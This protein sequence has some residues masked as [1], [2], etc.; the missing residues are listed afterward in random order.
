MTGTV[1]RRA[2]RPR[3]TVPRSVR[4]IDAHVHLADETWAATMGDDRAR[5]IARAFGREQVVVPVH[6]MAAEYRDR[7]MMAVI[8]NA[9]DTTVTGR[10]SVPNDHIAEVVAGDPD[11]FFGMGVIDPWQGKLAER[12]IDHISELG[13][14]GVGELNP[15][16]QHFAPNDERFHP[17]WRRA[18]DLGLV[19][20]FHGGYAAAGS[21]T[22]GGGGVKLRFARPILLDDVAADF[23][24]LRIVCAHPSWPWESEALAVTMHKRN[25]FLDLSGVA[26]RYLSDEVRRYVRRRISDKVLFG[27]DWPSLSVERWLREFEDLDLDE[28]VRRR[29][30]LGNALHLFQL[31]Q[32]DSTDECSA[33]AEDRGS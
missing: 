6:E 29:V 20:L 7:G 25:V 8:V 24:S 13:L 19:V 27:S 5:S 2:A 23:P 10:P 31:E 21:N 9:T 16:R 3:R 14:I 15:A 11:V 18:S 1:D 17:L 33:P 12:E 28:E 26:P 32:E 22:P 30:L 4:A